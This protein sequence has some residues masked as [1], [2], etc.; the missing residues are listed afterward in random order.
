GSPSVR[1]DGA[2][3]SANSATTGSGGAIY[4]TAS[5]SRAENCFFDGNTATLNGGAIAAYAGSS[6]EVRANLGSTTL[7]AEE[8]ALPG[9]HNSI[10]ATAC[11]PALR[12]CSSFYGNLADSDGDS[13][14]YGGAIYN[15]D[16]DLSINQTY[17]HRNQAYAGGAIFQNGAAASAVVT[18][19]L[20]YSNTVTY[21]LGSGIRQSG[22]AFTVNHV[23]IANNT[24]GS[25]FSAYSADVYAAYNSIAWG[26]VDH[27]GFSQPTTSAECNIDNGGNAGT[28]I[29][30][31]F[32]AP[33]SGE[34]Y[35]LSDTSPAIDACATGQ[36]SDLDGRTR[37]VG[38]GYD[39]GA[40]EF[41]DQLFI[42]KSVSQPSFEPGQPIAFTLTLANQGNF[43]ATHVILT[44]TLT[45]LTGITIN[46]TLTL[47]DTGHTPPYTWQVQDLIPTQSGTVTIAGTLVTP[48]AAGTYTNTAFIAADGDQVGPNNTASAS[49]TVLN[50]APT[51]TTFPPGMANLD[52]LYTYEIHTLD[53]N[54]DLVSITAPT[55][56]AWLTLTDH[57]DGSAT[58]SGTPHLANLGDTS[59]T[60][61]ATDPGGLSEDQPFTIQLNQAPSFTSSPLTAASVGS[62]YTYHVTTQDATALFLSITPNTLPAWLSLTDHGDGSA[63]LSGTPALANAGSNSVSL[64]VT[65]D[66]GLYA[67]QSFTIVVNAAPSFTSL[68][69]TAATPGE[70]YT[71]HITAQ[72]ATGLPLVITAPPLPA[73]LSLVDNGDG[74]ATLS[75]IPAPTHAGDHAVSLRV[76]DTL[77]LYANQT[78]TITVSAGGQFYLPITFK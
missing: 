16:G 59:V 12:Q 26:N 8:A 51:I 58:L 6:L 37:P 19:T 54:G 39:M 27:S 68:P 33:G 25:G 53:R 57:G 61:S 77:G 44:D 62:L 55:L 18:D 9:T 34:N 47:T 42:A 69:L 73:W 60:L 14:G 75:G 46:S 66:G 56:P 32:I 17:F 67:D 1:C 15:N 52:Q 41:D 72:D 38:A 65:D 2:V 28:N 30:P 48:L 40:Y 29:D 50:V 71:Y 22:G 31:Q 36:A 3:L 70:T 35:H 4:L 11:N 43:T 74:T 78:F 20:I 24:G 64:R 10:Q 23:T 45:L 63:T 13:S 49:F 7:A 21:P 5:S 76:A